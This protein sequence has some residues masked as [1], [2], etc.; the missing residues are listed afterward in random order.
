[1]LHKKRFYNRRLLSL[2][3]A[4]IIFTVTS[5]NSSSLT[6]K[7]QD[8]LDDNLDF[9]AHAIHFSAVKIQQPLS[10][11]LRRHGR[12]P[13][14]LQEQAAVLGSIDRRLE[15]HGVTS[16][17]LLVIDRT[18]VLVEYTFS[19]R[20]SLRFPTL[21]ESW[22]IVFSNKKGKQLEVVAI[23]PSWSDPAILARELSYSVQ[24]VE[25]LQ[26]SFKQQLQTLLNNYSLTLIENINEPI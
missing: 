15:Q 19:N 17:R 13:E 1:M 11:F 26:Q 3:L 25:D 14:S 10:E 20:H 5:C 22:S 12:W 21:L 18:D 7:Q 2:T 24:L 4:G 8:A 16:A 23:Y 6:R 9:V